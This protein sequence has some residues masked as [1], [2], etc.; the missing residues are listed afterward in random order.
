MSAVFTRSGYADFVEG[1][2]AAGYDFVSFPEAVAAS[3]P[4]VCLLRHDVDADLGAAAELAQVERAA[5]ARATYFCMV[6]SPLYNV[7]GRAETKLID[8]IL[9]LG[10]WLGLHYDVAVEPRA[11]RTHEESITAEANMLA[12]MFGA[13]VEAVSFHQPA[14]NPS[15]RE[16]ETGKLVSAY[17]F[18]G[19]HYVTD[20]NKADDFMHVVDGLRAGL[21]P[22]IQILIHPLWW[23]TED[24]RASTE[25]LW[26]RA[27]LSNLER[28]QEQLAAMERAFGG[29]RRFAI[30]RDDEASL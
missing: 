10:H 6:R 5:D 16:V 3:A 17:D 26:D 18:H 22:R 28:S 21:H 27:I 25:D 8:E 7:F 12:E 14:A 19:F 30:T 11:G 9:G 13:P 1:A 24:P 20:A 29:R 23:V 15:V 2:R 4:R